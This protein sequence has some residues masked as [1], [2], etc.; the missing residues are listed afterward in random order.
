MQGWLS[1]QMILWRDRDVPKF[2]EKL[3]KKYHLIFRF[4]FYYSILVAVISLPAVLLVY[5]VRNLPAFSFLFVII[6]SFNVVKAIHW[7]RN[8]SILVSEEGIV[9]RTSGITIG[10]SWESIEEIRKVFIFVFATRQECLIVD[11]SKV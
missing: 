2:V 3:M 7:L 5:L 9:Y 1:C 10:T 4:T 8:E 11:Q 6:L